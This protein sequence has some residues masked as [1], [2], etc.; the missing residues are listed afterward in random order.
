M[1]FWSSRNL[2]CA[3]GVGDVMNRTW[4]AGMSIVLVAGS[5]LAQSAAPNAKAVQLPT[6]YQKWPD[7]DVAYIIAPEEKAKFVAPK[8]D[9]ER[10]EFVRQF[11]LRRDPTPNAEPN[12][13]K[14]EHYR[15]IAYSN[16]HFAEKV[17]GWKTDRGRTYIL[18]GPPDEIT[19]GR[20]S[21]DASRELWLYNSSG[22][23]VIFEDQCRCGEFVQ[24]K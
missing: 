2:G 7:E 13:F 14:Q 17:A 22:T 5:L 12:E 23:N 20:N 3:Q 6:V 8:D 11:W 4:L 1:K 10:D 19:A 16:V 18:Q 9:A 15:R 21:M 24:M